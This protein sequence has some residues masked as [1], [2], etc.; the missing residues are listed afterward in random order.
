M[1][2]T[3]IPLIV[4]GDGPR[5]T[6]GLARIARDLCVR[7]YLKEEALGIRVLQ[8]GLDGG[9]GWHWQAWPFFGFQQTEKEFGRRAVDEVLEQL[10]RVGAP[11]PIV[12]MITDPARCFDLT[13]EVDE[14][15]RRAKQLR[16]TTLTAA[17][18]FWG[19]FPIDA[20]NIHQAIG[21]PA[22]QAVQT[23]ERVIAYGRY[24]AGVL[25]RTLAQGTDA[26]WEDIALPSLPHGLEPG[27]FIP[28]ELKEADRGFAH[29]AFVNG[30]QRAIKIGCV[31]TNQPRKDLALYFST[32]SELQTSGS[33]IL[34]WL[35]TDRM[36][37]AWDVGQLA[38]DFQIPRERI[39]VSVGELTDAELAAR[40]SW[41]DLTI[42]PGLGEGFGYPI[43]ES[44]ACGTP[45]VHGNYA[46]GVELVP[47]PAWLVEPFAWRLESCYNLLRPVYQPKAFAQAVRAVMAGHVPRSYC[48]GAVRHLGWDQLWPRWRSWITKG[49]DAHRARLEGADA[50]QA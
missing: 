17:A 33:P 45:V 19:Y 15:E 32:L 8:V 44:L 21:G 1:A 23:C 16:Y 39:Y 27:A 11:T 14:A 6:S 48:Q 42:A 41:C 13:R 35:H 37:H 29:W 38:Y 24:G 30:D 36:T 4:F 46:G 25:K 20:H 5:Y 28:R 2:D 34:A 31:A 7:L 22:A 10:E 9:Q 50:A 47:T 40:Y 49:L 26:K 3:R 12:W 43:V 18:Q